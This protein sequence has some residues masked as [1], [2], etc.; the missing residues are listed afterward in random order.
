[1]GRGLRRQYLIP[2]NHFRLDSKRLKPVLGSTPR[3]CSGPLS[4]PRFEQL[5]SVLD[6]RT[7]L[8]E[9]KTCQFLEA[10]REV[11]LLQEDTDIA[12]GEFAGIKVFEYRQTDDAYR[13]HR[14]L[15]DRLVKFL[16]QGRPIASCLH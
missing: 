3:P 1:M 10:R 6:E 13:P 14:A 5:G 16:G 8:V 2:G 12:L 11:N 15:R 7:R 4:A 9:I